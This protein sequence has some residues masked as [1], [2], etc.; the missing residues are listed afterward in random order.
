MPGE[1]PEKIK[2]QIEEGTEILRK[3][4]VIAFPTDTVYGLGAGAYIEKA[5]ARIFEIKQRRR[6]MALPVLLAEVSQVHQVARDLPAYAWRLINRFWPGGLTL[7]VYRTGLIKDIITAGGDTVAVRLPDH[8]VPVALIKGC[9]M[10]VIGTSANVSGQ[11]FLM[12]AD[13]V[14]RQLGNTVDLIIDGVP[15]PTGRES[16]VVDVTGE[17]PVIMRA[18]AIPRTEIEKVTEAA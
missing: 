3:G 5:I 11:S 15:A 12:A 1:L 8:P 17:V 16:T 4:G 7:V 6:E 10:P 18:G 14:R 13:D 9:G 2:K